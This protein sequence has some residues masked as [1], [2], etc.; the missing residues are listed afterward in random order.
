MPN[1]PRPRCPKCGAAMAPLFRKGA[2]GT[3]YVR[4]GSAFQCPTCDVL[5]HGRGKRAEFMGA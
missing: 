3:S 1:K 2:R 5:A 4:A